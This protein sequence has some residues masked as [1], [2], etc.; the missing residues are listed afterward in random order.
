MIEDKAG[1]EDDP[2]GK[3]KGGVKTDAKKIYDLLSRASAASGKLAEAIGNVP[4]TTTSAAWRKDAQD[5]V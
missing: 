5:T 2:E 3:S 4:K 1:S